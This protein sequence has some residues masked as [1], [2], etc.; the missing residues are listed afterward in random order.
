MNGSEI[1]S[2]NFYEN[3]EPSNEERATLVFSVMERHKKELR[4]LTSDGGNMGRSGRS[5]EDRRYCQGRGRELAL[6]SGRIRKEL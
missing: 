2:L 6:C 3:W 5:Q 4:I 1:S